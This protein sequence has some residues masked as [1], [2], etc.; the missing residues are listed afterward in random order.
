MRR[1]LLNLGRDPYR[2]ISASRS[3]GPRRHYATANNIFFQSQA[4]ING[5]WLESDSHQVFPVHNP[6]TSEVIGEVA[7]CD[8]QDFMFA[9]QA[10][11]KSFK[12]WSTTTA[13]HRSHL[14]RQLADAQMANQKEL[15]EI[16][17][18]ESGKPIK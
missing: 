3:V 5:R 11:T 7:D 10:A 14:L 8:E 4:Y 1:I 16:L 17:T 9:A 6:S 13:K 2:H 15:A 12:T 18:L